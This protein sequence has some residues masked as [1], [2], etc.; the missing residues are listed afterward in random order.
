MISGQTDGEELVPGRR[1]NEF[2]AISAHCTTT[3]IASRWKVGQFRFV[4]DYVLS[5]LSLP[6]RHG[7][8]RPYGP[9]KRQR[10]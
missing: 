9:L 6:P 7:R 10:V 4:R 2:F 1:G 8:A 3:A 5:F